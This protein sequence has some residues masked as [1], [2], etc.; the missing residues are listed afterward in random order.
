MIHLSAAPT[1]CNLGTV[2]RSEAEGVERFYRLE[3]RLRLVQ[4]TLEEPASSSSWGG[5]AC[6]AVPRSFLNEGSCKLLP[7]CLPLG[8]AQV[9]VLLDAASL[10][11]FFEVGGRYVFAIKGLRTSKPPCNRRARWKQLDCSIDSCSPS[12]L[13]TDDLAAVQGELSA[14]QGWLR[15]VDIDCSNVPA[16]AVVQVGSQHFQHTHLDEFNVYDFTDWVNSHPGGPD[17]ITRW[18]NE[19]YKLSSTLTSV[20]ERVIRWFNCMYMNMRATCYTV[21]TQYGIGCMMS[22]VCRCFRHLYHPTAAGNLDKSLRH[23]CFILSLSLGW[24]SRCSGCFLPAGPGF[25]WPGPLLI[26]SASRGRAA[27]LQRHSAPYL[28]ARV[29]KDRARDSGK[30]EGRG[31]ANKKREDK[32]TAIAIL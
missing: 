5:G 1:V 27:R 7:G 16:Q 8:T 9:Q 14:A 22:Y 13:S 30:E 11:Q 20:E 25:R 3:P 28:F 15:D 12:S 19:A 29:R 6:P 23:E 18:T 24:G 4:N 32:K 10:Q 26:G 21:D 31:K 2:V 17:K